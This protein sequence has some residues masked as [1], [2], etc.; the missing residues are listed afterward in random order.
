[1]AFESDESVVELTSQATSA[2]EP[3]PPGAEPADEK[4]PRRP[5]RRRP[6]RRR[7]FRRSR[8]AAYAVLLVALTGVGS[9]Y[10]LATSRNGVAAAGDPSQQVSAGRALFLQGCSSC[11]GA[12]AQGGVDAPSLIGVG[13]AAVDFQVSTGRMPLKIQGAQALAKK[14]SYT[15]DEI[16]SLAA[17]I[18]SLAPGRRVPA[19]TS[20]RRLSPTSATAAT[21]SARTARR[22]TTS[23]TRRRAGRRQARA[24]AVNASDKQIYEAML[25]GP[26]TMPVFGDKQLTTQEKQDIIAYL[27]EMKAV[28]DPGGA[29]LGRS[30]AVAEGLVACL[31]GMTVLGGVA[32]WIGA[33]AKKAA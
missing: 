29:N 10:G 13:A 3:P 11:H 12:A 32:M 30:G 2:S 15:P 7:P 6:F 5:F 16:A 33:R 28:P 8:W 26:G 20:T 21:C 14:P 24:V 25:T 18:A 31:A 4:R 17:Y 19:R 27:N 1:M 22:A 9:A 23:W